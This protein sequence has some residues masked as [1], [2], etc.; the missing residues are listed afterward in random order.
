[1]T[2]LQ[3]IVIAVVAVLTMSAAPI[4]IK[5]TDANAI[6]VGIVRLAIAVAAFSPWIVLR[7]RLLRLSRRQ[8]RQL[9]VIGA[10]FGLHW[11]TFFLSIKLA[12]AAIAALTILTYSMQYLVL[13]FLF[14]GERV[15]GVEWLA[16]GAS[17]VGCVIVSPEPSLESGVSVGIAIGLCSALLYAAMPLLHQRAGDIGTPERTWGQFFFA[18]LVFLPLSGGAN[19]GLD[20]VDVYQLLALGLLC[21]VISHGLWVKASTELPAIYASMIYFMYLPG[22]VIGSALFLDEAI[23]PLKLTGCALV[24]GSSAALSLY[25]YRRS[26]L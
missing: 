25:R 12:T 17:F 1:M 5:S 14:N 10:V 7:G 9:L 11:L 3:L 13:A 16:I 26:R 18:L 15:D 8:W 4:L 22:A 2:R 19:W 20:R 6:T 23:T 24:L 21:T